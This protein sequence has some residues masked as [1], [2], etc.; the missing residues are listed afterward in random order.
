MEHINYTSKIFVLKKKAMRAIN[1]R[2]YNEHTNAHFKCNKIVKLS[3]QYNL[4]VSNYIFQ[5][6]H[7]NIDEEIESKFSCKKSNS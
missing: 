4:Q 1:N 7:F 2:A 5:L 3:D 6:S